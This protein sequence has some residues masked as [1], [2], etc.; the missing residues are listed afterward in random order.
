MTQNKTRR[1]NLRVPPESGRP[2]RIDI[3][4]ENFLDIVYATD[5]SVAGACIAVPHRFE[6][7]RLDKL[8]S[9]VVNLPEPVSASF[10]TLGS[11]RH[12]SG[13]SFGVRFVGMEKK[14]ESLVRDYVI[15]LLA[16]H[17]WKRATLFRWGLI[18]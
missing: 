9:L 16:L 6:G 12:L 11:I 2:I 1:K 13:R 7:C 17:D 10:T 14:E 3:N 4:G 15:H 8:V 5:V 18:R